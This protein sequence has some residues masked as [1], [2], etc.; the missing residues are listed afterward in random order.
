MPA[1]SYTQ[2]NSAYT[3]PTANARIKYLHQ[4]LFSPSTPTLLQAAH[5]NQLR[6]WPGLME[7][8]IRR[9]LQE[10]PATSKDH[11]KLP[12]QGTRTTR[13][14][15]GMPRAAIKKLCKQLDHILDQ[16]PTG[17]TISKPTKAPNI[18][19]DVPTNV[20]STNP[21]RAPHVHTNIPSKNQTMAPTA[22]LQQTEQFHHAF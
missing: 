6:M 13:P 9:C 1:A 17:T 22:N 19:P 15:P 2:A 5:N 12:K 14:R 4:T 8:V 16:S 3:M 11:M 20:P 10:A 7:A 18:V 21:S